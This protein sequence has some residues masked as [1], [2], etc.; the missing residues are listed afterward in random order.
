MRLLSDGAHSFE[1]DT[2]YK[3]GQVEDHLLTSRQFTVSALDTP[4]V[5][6]EPRQVV[7]SGDSVTLQV[8]IKGFPSCAQLH[9]TLS[10][11]TI[12]RA[13]KPDTAGYSALTSGNI[14]DFLVLPSATPVS[15]N[16]SVMTLVAKVPDTTADTTRITISYCYALG[17]NQDTFKVVSLKGTDVLKS[18]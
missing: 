11:A 8:R 16:V 15:G 10:N 12:K 1:I 5:F 9:I 13:I 18:F 14:A 7:R 17:T 6:L 4:A 3:D 2:R